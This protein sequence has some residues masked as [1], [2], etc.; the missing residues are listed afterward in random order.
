METIRIRPLTEADAVQWRKQRLRMLREHPE[1]FGSAYEDQVG[2]PLDRFAQRLREANTLDNLILGAFE[3]DALVG[4]VGMARDTGVKVRHKAGI[5]SVYIAPEARGRGVA[6]A[7]FDDIIARARALAGTGAAVSRRWG[8]QYRGSKPVSRARLRGV[9]AGA[10]RAQS[11]RALRGRGAD[12]PLA[13][14]RPASGSICPHVLTTLDEQAVSCYGEDVARIQL[15]A[16]GTASDTQSSILMLRS[17]RASLHPGGLAS[18]ACAQ[19]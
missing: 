1:A 8:R 16:R 5:V 3:G 9:R 11:R 6:R 12:G 15:D 14:R 13:T 19:P 17:S 18:R 4:S 7:L 10:A 2:W